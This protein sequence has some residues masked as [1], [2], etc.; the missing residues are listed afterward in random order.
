MSPLPVA[1][2]NCPIPVD[3]RPLPAIHAVDLRKEFRRRERVGR[4]LAT[5]T[6]LLR[7][8]TPT[9]PPRDRPPSCHRAY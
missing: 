2:P 1:A 7:S 4:R 5:T 3:G 9:V 8:V 6:N